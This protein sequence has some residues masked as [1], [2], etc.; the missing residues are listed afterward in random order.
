[1]AWHDYPTNYSNGTKVEGIADMF[2]FVNLSLGNSL[3]T[4]LILLVWS[5]LFG[6]SMVTGVK[7]AMAVSSFICFVLSIYLWAL[8]M[9]NPV[10]IIT[11]IVLTIIG[12]IG[13]SNKGRL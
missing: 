8:G 12:A 7:K 10:F 5:V 2:E 4:I 1:M 13:S 9:L 3:G 11:F 6:I